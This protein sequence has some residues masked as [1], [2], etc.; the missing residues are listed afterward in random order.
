MFVRD[1]L[2]IVKE[3]WSKSGN[4]DKENRTESKTKSESR[5]RISASIGEVISK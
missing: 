1:S 5:K 4:L 2:N 3:E